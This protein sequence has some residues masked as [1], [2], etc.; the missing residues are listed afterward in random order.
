MSSQPDLHALYTEL[1]NTFMAQPCD[2]NKCGAL[3][4]QLKV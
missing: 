4:M 3:L 1:I 2:L